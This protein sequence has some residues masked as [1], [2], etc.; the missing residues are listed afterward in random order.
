LQKFCRRFP[1]YHHLIF[2]LCGLAYLFPGSGFFNGWKMG[3]FDHSHSRKVDQPMGA[4]M[5]VACE[6]ISEIGAFDESFGIFFNDVDFCRR[7]SLAGYSN[8]YC[9][10]AV[11][12]HYGGGSVKRQKPKMIWLGHIAMF[13]YFRKQEKLR[14]ASFLIKLLRMPL[15]YCAGLMLLPAAIPRSIYHMIRRVI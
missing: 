15:P 14:E 4:A 10:E 13:K 3:D 8:Y 5:L 1:A 9:A 6:R 7:L 12:E 2:E 11:I